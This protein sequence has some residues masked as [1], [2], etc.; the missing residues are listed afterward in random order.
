MRIPNS[1]T[2]SKDLPKRSRR[3]EV[4][5]L[6]VAVGLGK[7]GSRADIYALA[8]KL[9]RSKLLEPPSAK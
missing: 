6:V 9:I 8:S 4:I 3:E 2:I 1:R 7:K 5:V